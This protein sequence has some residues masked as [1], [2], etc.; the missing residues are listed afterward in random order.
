MAEASVT[1]IDIPPEVS[2]RTLES[3]FPLLDKALLQSE[4][5]LNGQ[6]INKADT[7]GLQL[8][9]SFLK[10][11]ESKN[12]QATWVSPSVSLCNTA[13]ILGLVKALKLEC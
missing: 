10:S 1:T 5:K 8:I 13:R 7:A 4:I 11:T 3:V 6:A 12:I 9:A 2:I